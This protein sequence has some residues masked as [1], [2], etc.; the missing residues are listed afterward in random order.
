M[1]VQIG[2]PVPVMCEPNGSIVIQSSMSNVAFCPKA[3]LQNMRIKTE[4]HPKLRA[5][6]LFIT[7]SRES[8]DL[9]LTFDKLLNGILFTSCSGPQ[10]ADRVKPK[11]RT[12]RRKEESAGQ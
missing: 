5:N 8:D 1:T 9:F 4:I 3:K 7:T 12:F 2:V 11:A 6:N 10:Q